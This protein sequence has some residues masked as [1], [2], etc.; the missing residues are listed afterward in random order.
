MITTKCAT[1]HLSRNGSH[2]DKSVTLGSGGNPPLPNQ[3]WIRFAF[4]YSID[5]YTVHMSMSQK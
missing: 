2:I 3:I 5:L 1:I 4:Q